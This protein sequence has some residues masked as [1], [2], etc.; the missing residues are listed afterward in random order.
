MHAV[1]SLQESRGSGKGQF[2]IDYAISMPV[3]INLDLTNKFGDIYINEVQGKTR[4]DLGYGNLEARKLGNSDNTLDIKFS[5][6][7]V[8]WIK[9]AVTSM[10]YSEMHLDYAGSLRLKILKPGCGKDHRLQCRIRRG[11]AEH[12]EILGG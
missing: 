12:G 4:V 1:T 5:K 6:V 10:K 9:G 7:R 3:T 11:E 8:N 2:S